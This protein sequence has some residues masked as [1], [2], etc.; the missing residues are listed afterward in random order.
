VAGQDEF[1]DLA[2]PAPLSHLICQWAMG[3]FGQWKRTAYSA[4]QYVSGQWDN[5]SMRRF[6]LCLAIV[7][8]SV[9]LGN[10][11]AIAA[12]N[13]WKLGDPK[14]DLVIEFSSKNPT[15]ICGAT[16]NEFRI[17]YTN[18]DKQVKSASWNYNTDR[19][20]L[21]NMILPKT[22]ISKTTSTNFDKFVKNAY[23]EVLVGQEWIKDSQYGHFGGASC[24]ITYC[25]FW[26]ENNELHI[27]VYAERGDYTYPTLNNNELRNEL[28]SNKYGPLPYISES[29][30]QLRAVAILKSSPSK[31]LYSKPFAVSYGNHPQDWLQTCP[32][33]TSTSGS[34]TPSTPQGKRACTGIEAYNLNIIKYNILLALRF[35]S[36]GYQAEVATLRSQ[37][38][39]IEDSCD[40]DSFDP[41]KMKQKSIQCTIQT[42]SL[43][44]EVQ[45]KFNILNDQYIE[46]LK[47]QKELVDRINFA[48]SSGKTQDKTKYQL[49]YEKVLKDVQWIYSM[50]DNTI[51]TFKALDSTCANSGITEPKI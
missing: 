41:V 38:I 22:I 43:L 21:I 10:T 49:Q 16:K 30:L 15:G 29:I 50:R 46:N 13:N 6:L 33:G 8:G 4:P 35:A 9:A 5:H 45:G 23:F 24:Q 27:P 1:V 17:N 37:G 36:T 12:G 44:L 48:G 11:E 51:S 18:L 42:K 7:I 14:Q 31:K 3:V 47:S 19:H 39:L 32:N 26:F 20:C 25:S 40:I 34:A 2:R 28:C